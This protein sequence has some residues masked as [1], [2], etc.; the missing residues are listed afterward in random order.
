MNFSNFKEAWF[1]GV[2]E[3]HFS[4]LYFYLRSFTTD[5]EMI[6]DIIQDA[7][8]TLLEKDKFETIANVRNYLYSCVRNS[9]FDKIKSSKKRER[10][11]IE[12]L[13][14]VEW[15]PYETDKRTRERL[16][17]ITR[18]AV[19]NLP[20]ACKS[21]FTMAK[22]EGMS[23]KQIADKLSLSVKTV[24]AQMGIAFKKIREYVTV[25]TFEQ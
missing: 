22:V 2:Y 10:I 6:Q 7:F 17:Y 5:E 14:E 16:L 13:N 12:M 1:R 3:R 15:T 18:E 19:K 21:I 23:Y 20:P 25:A 11:R 24:E 4:E 8:V 9:L